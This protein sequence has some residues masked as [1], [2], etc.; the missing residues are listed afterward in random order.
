ME[1]LVN[2]ALILGSYILGSVPHLSLLAKLQHIELNGDSHES[3]WHKASKTIVVIGILGEFAKGIVPVIVGKYLGFDLA[4]VA[5]AG[6]T[7]VCGQM[8]PIFSRFDGE[9][10]NSIAIAMVITLAPQPA[11]MCI[12][13][14]IVSLIFRTVP[15]LIAKTKSIDD[16]PIIGGSHSRS[17][18]LGM[19]TCFLLLPFVGWYLAEPSE[20]I[21][22]FSALF[23]LIMIR[24]LT[25]GIRDDFKASNDMIGIIINRLLYDRSMVKWR[26]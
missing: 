24:R 15:R 22:C 23:I 2:L 8:W 6:L 14:I 16:R 7:A 20:I 5:I 10:G 11:L 1:L 21:W 4:I 19:F 25:A 13:P 18:P 17:L 3:L 9:K 12:V 26:Q